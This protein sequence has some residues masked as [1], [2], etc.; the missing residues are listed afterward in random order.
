MKNDSEIEK[1]RY[2]NTELRDAVDRLTVRL[3]ILANDLATIA[4]IADGS[5]TINS[6]PHI[7]KIARTALSRS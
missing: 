2:D 4:D 3:T 5:Q 7:A 6:L 1:L